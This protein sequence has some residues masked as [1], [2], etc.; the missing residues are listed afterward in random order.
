MKERFGNAKPPRKQKVK[1]FFSDLSAN[2]RKSTKEGYHLGYKEILSYSFGSGGINALGTLSTLIALNSLTILIGSL[3]KL[4]PSII[5]LMNS[6]LTIIN[7]VKTPII[8]TIMDNT[9]RKKGKFKPYII[10]MGIPTMILVS[11]LPF[12]PLS[13]IDTQ[14]MTIFSEPLSLAGLMIFIIHVLLSITWP[15][16]MVTNGGIGQVITPNSLERAKLFSFHQIF[17]NLLPSLITIGFPILSIL[18][19][20][21]ASTGQESILSYRVWFPIFA[22][23]GFLSSLIMYFNC[24]ERI[25][26]EKD[27]KPQVNFWSGVKSLGKNKYFW[28]FTISAAF[29]GIRMIGNLANWINVYSLKSDVATSITTTLLG[30]A[31]IPGMLLTGYMVRKFGKRNLVLGAGFGSAIL[32][33][34]M[35]L[36]P[37]RPILLLIMLFFQNFLNGFAL[38][39]ALMPADALD[40]QQLKTGERLESFWGNFHMLILGIVALGSGLIAPAVLRFSGMPLGADVLVDEVIRKTVFRNVSIVAGIACI[41]QFL[42][43]FFWDL[44]ESKHK[45]IILQ[46]EK[47]AKEKNSIEKS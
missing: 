46:L 6:F 31:L 43:Y 35:I 44:T 41:F 23:C 42:P 12:V 33:V 16:L 32:Y 38:C 21:G 24:E 5:Y 40:L 28:I 20:N 39:I 27:Y 9:K 14:I 22:V 2:W 3:Y 29:G 26:V 30:N 4:S 17:A 34:P 37:N 36:F 15:T 10:W 45:E 47:I 8:S 13:W 19:I 1:D 11:L 25:I 7:L 18:T